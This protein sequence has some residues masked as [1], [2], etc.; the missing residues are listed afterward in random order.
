MLAYS[1]DPWTVSSSPAGVSIVRLRT[2][3]TMNVTTAIITRMK[4]ILVNQSDQRVVRPAV[5][6]WGHDSDN[7]SLALRICTILLRRKRG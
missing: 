7:T 4:L 2:E 1:L 6:I 5:P 3:T